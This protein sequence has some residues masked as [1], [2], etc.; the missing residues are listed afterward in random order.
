MRS[1]ILMEIGLLDICCHLFLTPHQFLC[2]SFPEQ[3][4]QHQREYKHTHSWQIITTV[5]LR[6]FSC[7]HSH[8]H[9]IVHNRNQMNSNYFIEGTKRRAPSSRVAE[10]LFA[11]FF[12]PP[13]SKRDSAILDR[14]PVLLGRCDRRRRWSSIGGIQRV[15]QLF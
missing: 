14:T 5:V 3:L 4:Q 6:N 15:V 7:P 8:P 2:P 10:K 13:P 12:F 11:L 1:I 9:L